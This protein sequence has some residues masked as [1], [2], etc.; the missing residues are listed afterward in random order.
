MRWTG[1]PP[2]IADVRQGGKN[3]SM[4]RD[5]AIA[6]SLAFVLAIGGF[7]GCAFSDRGSGQSDG[8]LT[9]R[10]AQVHRGTV[11]IIAIETCRG[12]RTILTEYIDH[13]KTN[14]VY[15]VDEDKDDI[16]V[17]CGGTNAAFFGHYHDRAV[18]EEFVRGQDGQVT[19]IS[20]E[21]YNRRLKQYRQIYAPGKCPY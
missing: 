16:F 2:V 3:L 20:E 10:K 1:R 5:C 11:D 18:F 12:G 13:G 21:E 19:P 8:R 9:V 17:E 6:T 4:R 7:S 15:N 14:R